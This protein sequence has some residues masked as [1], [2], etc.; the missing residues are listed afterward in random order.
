MTRK[1]TPCETCFE[2]CKLR[3]DQSPPNNGTD[4]TQLANQEVEMAAAEWNH[5][6]PGP[7]QD[8]VASQKAAAET[9]PVL[10]WS[11]INVMA[12]QHR[13]KAAAD[14]IRA[15]LPWAVLELS[16]L[17]VGTG[18]F[19]RI[20]RPGALYDGDRETAVSLQ[21]GMMDLLGA[22]P[23]GFLEGLGRIDR[24]VKPVAGHENRQSTTGTRKF[25]PHVDHAAG[26]FPWET[27]DGR[28]A[29]PDWLSIATIDNP[30]A[31]G[32]MFADPKQVYIKLLLTDEEAARDLMR[33]EA[34]LPCPPSVQP[35]KISANV[36]VIMQGPNGLPGIRVYPRTIAETER[37]E[38]A[39][40]VLNEVL[41]DPD[42]WTEIALEPGQ[43]VIARGTAIPQARRGN[44]ST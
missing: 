42:L 24:P 34:S 21:M 30:H 35:A 17:R 1:S 15:H 33:P 39:L 19:Y 3:N 10:D 32:T 26:R 14:I 37:M 40:N 16:E 11:A 6:W 36:P 23:L 20:V 28:M 22:Y 9:D 4:N 2:A 25:G 7:N 18:A 27:N 44:R 8:V 31:I 5:G 43:M 38:H 13:A 41:E 12:V 29:Q